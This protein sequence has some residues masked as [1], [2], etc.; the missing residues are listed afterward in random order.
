MKALRKILLLLISL[1]LALLLS[2]YL[3]ALSNAVIATDRIQSIAHTTAP[4][5]D[6][7]LRDALTAEFTPAGT[8]FL[9]GYDLRAQWFRLTVAPRPQGGETVLQLTSNQLDH[10]TLFLPTRMG[11]VSKESGDHVP[12]AQREAKLL[13]VS[14]ILPPQAL[15]RT[16]YLRVQS[17]SSLAFQIGATDL[18]TAEGFAARQLTLHVI[19]FSLLGMGVALCAMRIRLSP[20]GLSFASLAFATVYFV[21]SAEVLGYAQVLVNFTQATLHSRITDLSAA[22]TV[23]TSILLQRSF[24]AQFR[25]IWPAIWASDALACAAVVPVVL[26]IANVNVHIGLP[27]MV[28]SLGALVAILAM[29][30][31]LHVENPVTRRA[32]YAGYAT[33]LCFTCISIAS[34]LGL[35]ELP[36]VS[37]PYVEVFGL[38]SLFI[39][40]LVLAIDRDEALRRNHAMRLSLVTARARADANTRNA[41]VQDG[42][43]HML[44]HEMRNHLT[45][46]QMSLPEIA[47]AET[48]NRLATSIR[49]LDRSLIEARHATW[50]TQGNWP[51]APRPLELVE[52]LAT[53]IDACAASDRIELRGED[54]DATITAD[55]AMLSAALSGALEALATLAP[56]DA[57]I[58]IDLGQ[59]APDAP[60]TLTCDTALSGKGADPAAAFAL[61]GLILRQMGGSLTISL[62]APDRLRLD[63]V[64]PPYSS[65]R[66]DTRS[67]T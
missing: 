53:A 50:L 27:L 22:L 37:R 17:T 16:L 62:P 61:V 19:Y 2:A 63:I 57:P 32:L 6:F 55:P 5:P 48:R 14:F 13:P 56:T 7:T 28:I 10:V 60:C 58:R 40:L 4:K 33:W 42:F 35:F 18:V 31:T 3:H 47:S 43:M 44:V 45:V 8:S 54:A 15:G 30:V 49:A 66:V 23:L 1:G 64:I 46:L 26:T 11:Y 65:A 25:P 38:N 24:L 51:V 39:I 34:R 12:F 59:A 67:V 20:S 52:V 29:L 21:Y 36:T 9:G 41:A